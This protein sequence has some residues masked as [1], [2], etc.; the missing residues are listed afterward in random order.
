MGII[1]PIKRG[2]VIKVIKY[3]NKVVKKKKMCNPCENLIRLLSHEKHKKKM[4]NCFYNILKIM[5]LFPPA[6]NENK[7]IYGKLIELELIKTINAFV[8][9][10]ELDKNHSSGSEYKND[11]II[12]NDKFSIKA[13]K[14]T[15]NVIVTN[16]FNKLNYNIHTNFIICNI[17]KHKLYIFPSTIVD[18]KYI[19][20]SN[21]NI[22]F[23]SSVF[24]HIEKNNK[25]FVYDFPVNNRNISKI[26]K[27]KTVN[28]YDYLYKIFIK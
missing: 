10:K 2:K 9:C 12:K 5:H 1:K 27:I 22:Y 14:N 8:S 15:S 16:K 23:K 7:F 20:D 25:G 18:K 17:M 26:Q 13:S 21:S 6:K 11:C 28:V 19:V 24:T 4:Q 3:P